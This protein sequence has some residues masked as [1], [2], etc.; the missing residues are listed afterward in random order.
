[1]PT[2]TTRALLL[3]AARV[4]QAAVVEIATS[5]Q[6]RAES[7]ALL[8]RIYRGMSELDEIERMSRTTLL[9]STTL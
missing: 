1:M 6:L 7:K 5:K 2:H 9:R 8:Q 4:Q 3:R